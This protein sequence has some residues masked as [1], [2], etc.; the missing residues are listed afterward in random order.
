MF[1]EV[2]T[3]RDAQKLFTQ[4]AHHKNMTIIFI[5]H[6]LFSQSKYARTI[7]LN[8]HYMIP[9]TYNYTSMI[10]LMKF[11]RDG[12]Q[13][14]TLAR[15]IY[16]GR[17]RSLI[18]AYEQCMQS[19]YAYILIDLSPEADDELRISTN[20]FPREDRVVFLIN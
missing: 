11:F 15:Q 4:T 10:I 2:I 18:S 19:S 14:R 20:I 12:S 9:W 5:T 6:N 13:V 3:N 7:S 17:W 16:P 8:F 1:T